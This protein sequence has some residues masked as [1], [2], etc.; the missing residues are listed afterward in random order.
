MAFHIGYSG[1]FGFSMSEIAR[2]PINQSQVFIKTVIYHYQPHKNPNLK[3]KYQR[4]L[5][6]M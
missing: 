1:G 3:I 5:I 2:F 4:V 6:P